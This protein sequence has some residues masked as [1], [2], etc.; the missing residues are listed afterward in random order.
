[1]TMSKITPLI[2]AVIMLA[3]TS[4]VALDWAELE[5]KNM[6]EADGRSGPDATVNSIISPRATTVNQNDG[7]MMHELNAG[8]EVDF[9]A[10]IQNTGDTAVTEMG[11]TLT[12]YLA[13][14]GNRGMIA[15]DANGDDLSWTNGDV[16]CD[17]T[18]VCPWSSL[19]AGTSLNFGKYTMMYQGAPVTWTPATGDYEVVFEVNAIGDSD[20]G[21]DQIIG[22]YV[23]VVDWTDIVLDLS[24]DSG[25]E[26]EGGSGDKAFTLTVGSGGS[27]SWIAKSIVVQLV[28]E[29]TLTSAVDSSGNTIMGTTLLG[30]DN[31]TLGGGFGTWSESEETYRNGEDDA[32]TTEGER[33][34]LEFLTNDTWYGVVSPNTTG[35]SGD[36]SVEANLVSYVMYGQLPDCVRTV[37]DRDAN[38]TGARDVVDYCE[39]TIGTDGEAANNEDTIE[40]K[41]QTFHDIGVS[42]LVINQGYAIGEDGMPM[43]EPSMPGI[44]DG[45]LNPSWSSV[46]ASVRHMGSD[47]MTTYDWKVTF[48]IENTGT[49]VTV[50]EEADNCTFGFGEPYM[51]ME[52]G[53]NPESMGSAFESGEACV[54][55]E[56]GPGIYNVTAT[57]SMVGGTVNDMSAR[58]DDLSIY[59]IAALN[60]RFFVFLDVEQVHT[61][62]DSTI[63]VG[64]EGFIT[65]TA[66]ADDADDD[67]GITL[68]YV[69]THPEM[70]VVDGIPVPS[71]CNGVGPAFATCQLTAFDAAWAGVQTYSVSVSDAYDSSAQDYVNVFVWNHRIA[72]DT[73]DTGVG[74]EYDLTYNGINP[75]EVTVDDLTVEYTEDL[76]DFGQ[77]GEYTSVAVIEY[78]PSTTYLSE[79]VKAQSMTLTYDPAS[80][81]PT[82]VFWVSANGQWAKLWSDKDGDS[83]GTITVDLEE[84]SQVLPQGHIAFMGGDLIE[85]EAPIGYPTGLTVDATKGG[86]I[87]AGWGY[88]GNV[89]PSLDWLEMTI[90]DSQNNCDTTQ[91]STDLEAYSLNGQTF[92]THGETYSFTLRVCNPSGECNLTV[93]GPVSATADGAIDG[94]PV[95]EQMSVAN[96]VD[97]DAWTVTWAVSGNTDDVAFWKVCYDMASWNSP[98]EM[99]ACEPGELTGTSVDIPIGNDKQTGTYFFTVVPCDALKNCNTVLAGID[100]SYVCDPGTTDEKGDDVGETTEGEI[101]T[102]AWA[103]IVGLIVVAFVV[104]AF[105]LSRGGDEGED[106]KDWDY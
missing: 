55:Y 88:G 7:S 79:D 81:A 1:M 92:T 30:T 35:E 69:W 19:D 77:V 50:T 62:P 43:G 2:L 104:G 99:P 6:T 78:I 27:S 47:L 15:K 13:E 98:G 100:I 89:N 82:S 18:F 65:L 51:H 8:D 21:N 9:E 38:G 16:V 58:N 54:W 60:N 72:E 93:A 91:E 64:G 11:I 28:V 84:D 105:I 22:H 39:V 4:L 32:N 3:S 90:C 94:S 59:K 102:G 101:P 31:T 25:K 45:P 96:N 40:G 71:E 95:A 68:N 24:W 23:S 75:F 76:T 20:V 26:V 5:Q 106:D 57:V 14:G 61:L 34:V 42:N 67:D 37:D 17:D 36:Y 49:G 83:T 56:F 86:D 10:F 44:T 87:I 48:D 12:I 73:T 80:F 46:Q 103:A 41:V 85:V 97:A 70:V 52:L 66:N 33:H 74:I 29:G 53:D 63:I